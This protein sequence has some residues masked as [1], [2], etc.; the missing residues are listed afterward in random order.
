MLSQLNTAATFDSEQHPC[1]PAWGEVPL[2]EAATAPAR[3]AGLPQP[4]PREGRRE[5]GG[6]R[7]SSPAPVPGGGGGGA[8]GRRAVRA[9]SPAGEAG[10]W[11][12][13]LRGGE[14]GGG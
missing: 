2:L 12:G 8:G 9:P 5:K 4:N 11:R 10:A 14:E 7:Q 1:R 13:A 3:P 6:G